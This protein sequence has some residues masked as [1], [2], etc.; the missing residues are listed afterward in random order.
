MAAHTSGTLRPA[1]KTTVG[2][3]SYQGCIEPHERLLAM[4]G[5]PTV[6]V[7]TTQELAT[8]DRL[9]MPGGESTTM[10]LFLRRYEME[11]P[12]R[13]FARTRPVWGICA[14][15]ILAARDV[16]NPQQHSL[17]LIDI[18]AHRNFYGPQT[19]SFST[20][21]QVKGINHPL[22]AHF[23]RAPRLEA[24]PS[25]PG[26]PPV[27]EVAWVTPGAPSA[28][29][30]KEAVFFVQGHVWACSFHVELG[31]DPSLHHHFC[32]VSPV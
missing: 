19:E 29:G 4:I 21:V 10:L 20:E 8:V 32:T 5:V 7:R 26:R 23:I 15:S 24:L 11:A 1:D 12:L 2:I 6:R 14:G 17:N 31:T 16:V 30:K 28:A 25:S 9:I 3:L 27:Q 18:K 13:E 22:A